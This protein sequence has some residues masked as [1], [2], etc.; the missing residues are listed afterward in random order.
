MEADDPAVIRFLEHA[1]VARVATV[2]RSGRPSITP[3]YF[4]RVKGHVWL[5]TAAWTL[6][7]R[8]AKAD[9]RVSVL[10]QLERDPGERRILRIKGNGQV[11]VDEKTWRA[12]ERRTAFKYILTLPG[13]RHYL[14][15][16]K[17]ARLNQRYHAQSA[18]KGPGCVIDVLPDVYEFLDENGSIQS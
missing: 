6:A 14:A 17:L 9:P 5:G 10:F 16:L 18:A 8:E 3:L 13:L 12:N 11:R 7:A 4:V 15:H 2:S 1:M